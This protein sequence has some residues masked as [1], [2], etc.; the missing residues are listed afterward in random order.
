MGTTG[1]I[2]KGMVLCKTVVLNAKRY[3]SQSWKP[4]HLM[5]ALVEDSGLPTKE[6]NHSVV[7]IVAEEMGIEIV[8]NSR[9]NVTLSDNSTEVLTQES[10]QI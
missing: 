8:R 5:A 3:Y 1:S 6:F 9:R 7:N 2:K 4:R 10:T